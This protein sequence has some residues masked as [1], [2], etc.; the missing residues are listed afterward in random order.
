MKVLQMKATMRMIVAVALMLL[1]PIQGVHGLQVSPPP[2][3]GMPRNCEAERTKRYMDAATQYDNSWFA[4]DQQRKAACAG[5]QD[6]F[7]NVDVPA[8]TRKLKDSLDALA[9]QGLMGTYSCLGVCSVA[10]VPPAVM[11]PSCVACFGTLYV[12]IAYKI[13]EAFSVKSTCLQTAQDTA[14]KCGRDAQRAA[15]ADLNIARRVYD[16]AIADADSEYQRCK[17]NAGG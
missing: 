6:A 3:P 2:R 8:C 15:D 12:S 14:S 5:C 1:I 4:I 7:Y 17:A 16:Q 11:A 10:I 13:T 9:A